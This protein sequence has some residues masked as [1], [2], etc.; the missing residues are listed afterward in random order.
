[1]NAGPLLSKQLKSFM[2]SDL[3]VVAR[4]NSHKPH[5]L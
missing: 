4:R 5:Y 3:V 2:H 1:M